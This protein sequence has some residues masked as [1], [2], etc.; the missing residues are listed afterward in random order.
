M[1]LVKTICGFGYFYFSA[2]AMDL[3][4]AI[5]LLYYYLYTTIVVVHTSCT[6]YFTLEIFVVRLFIY[7]DCGKEVGAS[8]NPSA[9]VSRSQWINWR[10]H[11]GLFLFGSSGFD[12]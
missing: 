7:G 5:Q 11:L 8:Q 1:T 6:N 2:R 10:P 12:F 3:V 9:V 4:V